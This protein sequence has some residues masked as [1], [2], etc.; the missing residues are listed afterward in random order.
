MSVLANYDYRITNNLKPACSCEHCSP[1]LISSNGWFFCITKNV[2]EN[3][4]GI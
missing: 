1:S 2:T 3:E 4:K